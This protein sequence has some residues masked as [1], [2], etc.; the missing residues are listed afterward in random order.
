M[1]TFNI[2]RIPNVNNA[3]ID[4]CDLATTLVNDNIIPPLNK[5]AETIIESINNS[6]K[7]IHDGIITAM[8]QLDS[9]IKNSINGVNIGVI[10][11]NDAVSKILEVV[12]FL[13][14]LIKTDTLFNT[15]KTICSLVIL[16]VIPESQRP[17]VLF[18]TNFFI[19]FVF[20]IFIVSPI[21]CIILI[22][23]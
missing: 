6:N 12:Y 22:F 3:T 8:E 13:Q 9:A 4:I 20:F 11:I 5:S 10:N 14:S 16:S 2:P 21:M 18:Y 19:Y 1:I 17:N 23:L 15:F 7:T